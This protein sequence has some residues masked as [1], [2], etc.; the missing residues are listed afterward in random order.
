M[1]RSALVAIG[2]LMCASTA[3]AQ[4]VEQFYASRNVTMIVPTSPGGINDISGR[5]VA[6]H[7]SRFIPGKPNIVVQNQP[8]AGG[9]ANAN[10]LYNSAEKDGTVLSMME[11]AIPLLA[12]T[13]D[14]NA[15]FEPLRFTWLGSLSS[16]GDD[17]YLVLINSAHKVRSV[18]DLKSGSG[19]EVSLGANRSGSTNLTFALIARDVLGLNVKVI[20][21]Y[22]GAAPMMLAQQRGELDGQVIGY[23]SVQAGQPDLWQNKKLIPIIQF[24]RASRHPAMPDV[25]TGRELAANDETRQLIALAEL[26]FEMALPTAA[27]PGIPA[28][29]AGALKAAYAAMVGDAQFREDAKKA[30]LE[31]SPI[32]GATV[33]KLLERAAATPKSVI[34]RYEKLAGDKG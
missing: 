12:L 27:P 26:P 13:G 21:G 1:I 34:D 24:G 7:L 19:M 30:K 20:R 11:R 31:I 10:V 33:V 32:D 2:L 18:A 22:T 3:G 29:R 8:G 14:P 17:A 4:T 28:D 6:R 9:L 16:Y 15:K 23:W 5:L 25:P